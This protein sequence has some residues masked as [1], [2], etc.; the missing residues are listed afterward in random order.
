MSEL[1]ILEKYLKDNNIPYQRYECHKELNEDDYI[2][3]LDRHQICVPTSE[4]TAWDVICQ[5]GSLGYKEGLLE[6]WGEIVEIDDEVEGYLTASDVI[7]RIKA[8][9]YSMESLSKWYAQQI[10]EI[11]RKDIINGKMD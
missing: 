11:K 1:D 6:A 9:K 7:Q 4:Y 5:E 10:V 2:F 8:R 3:H